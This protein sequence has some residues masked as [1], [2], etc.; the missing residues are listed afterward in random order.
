MFN[1]FRK[2]ATD[3]FSAEEKEQIVTAIKHA[4]HKTSGEIRVYVENK[5]SYVD[6]LDRAKE[7][8]ARHNMQQTRER[9]AVLIYVALV[10]R[11]FAILGD[12]GIHEKVGAEFWENEVKNMIEYF[13]HE[14]YTQGIVHVIEKVGNA[15]KD[16]FPYDE[17]N[18]KNE[19]PDD[20]LFGN[21]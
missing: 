12:E 4:E 14:N 21:K 9:N 7:I 16:H 13:R 19:L 18:D 10:H 2:K 20:I 5:C 6:A 1:I 11:Q 8:F 17:K 3:F 15:L